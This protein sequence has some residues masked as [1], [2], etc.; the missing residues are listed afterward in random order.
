MGLL[1][2]FALVVVAYG[3]GSRLALLLIEASGLQGVFFIPAGVTVAFLI[4]L[5]RRLWWLVLAAAGLTELFMDVVS[6]FSLSQALGF[7]TANVVEPVV[8]ASLVIATCGRLDLTRRQH[9]LWFTI[10]AVIAGPLVGGLLGASADFMLVGDEFVVTFLQWWLG[11][12]LG[13]LLIGGVI[14]AVGSSPDRRSLLSP[15]GFAL[16]STS[17][18]GTLTVL[19][20]TDLPLVF[21][22]LINVIL[23]G[24]L[25]GTR[26]SAIASLS[27]AATIAVVIALAPEDPILIGLTQ[28]AALVV[29]KLQIA[30]FSLTGLLVA[31]EANEREL[32]MVQSIR[33]A[34][35][36]D[37]A[38]R[39]RARDKAVAL[40]IQRGLLPRRSLDQAGFDVA[41]RHEAAE[42][43]LEVGGDWY[44]LI[45]LQDGCFGL[46]VGDVVG[47]GIEAAISMGRLR[48]A[49]SALALHNSDPGLLLAELDEFVSGPDNADF[50]TV[51]YAIVDP[52][53]K[54][55]EYASAGHPPALLLGADGKTTWLDA[56]Q[57][58]PLSG[59]AEQPRRRALAQLGEGAT[60][61]LYTDGLIERRGESLDV[62]FSRLESL[63]PQ[64]AGLS[65]MKMSSALISRLAPP[66]GWEDDV[67]VLVVKMVAGH[68]EA[69]SQTH[70]ALPDELSHIRTAVR[71][72]MERHELPE[73]TRDD[74]LVA[75]GEATSNAVRHAYSN[76][77]PGQVKVRL[78]ASDGWVEAEVSDDGRWQYRPDSVASPGMGMKIMRSVSDELDIDK[79][80]FGTSVSFRIPIRTGEQGQA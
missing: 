25:I 62:G 17:V 61:V 42:E 41:A 80:P 50:A 71:A 5:P 45:H 79:T 7:A 57:S 4:R 8:G 74:V 27:V 22:A 1:G 76:T 26:A 32:A 39:D 28:A 46:V 15:W 58:E 48:T 3:A 31:A 60:L 38:K 23:A 65:S 54:T 43:S 64:L 21:L 72:W 16:F 67:V 63:A 9:V 77:T 49:L 12:A 70:P 34:D 36:A 52:H 19:V 78:K 10:G 20:V 35:E 66:A 68:E 51:F 55:I 33:T 47:H 53:E 44:D 30:T 75:L 13:V 29:L 18:L 69:F 37:V 14:L 11:D 56:G 59:A 40:Q 2:L 24:A 6:G 73:T